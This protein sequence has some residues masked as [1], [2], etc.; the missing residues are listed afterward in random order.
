MQLILHYDETYRE[1]K[2]G[3]MGLPDIDSK[4]LM[5]INVTPI[6]ALLYTPVLIRCTVASLPGPGCPHSDLE[7]V[8]GLLDTGVSSCPGV[9]GG[10]GEA[11]LTWRRSETQVWGRNRSFALGHRGSQATGIRSGSFPQLARTPRGIILVPCFVAWGHNDLMRSGLWRFWKESD[12]LAKPR[13]APQDP[14]GWQC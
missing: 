8:Q 2:Y 9:P 6:A 13:D 3:N 11:L 12:Q 5:G 1:V 14:S 10:W 7:G 4:M